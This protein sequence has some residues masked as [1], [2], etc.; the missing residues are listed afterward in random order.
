MADGNATYLLSA[1]M[2]SVTSAGIQPLPRQIFSILPLRVDQRRS[3]P[4]GNRA[5][6]GLSVNRKRAGEQIAV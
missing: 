3:Q 1:R 4:V 5:A 6:F 2:A